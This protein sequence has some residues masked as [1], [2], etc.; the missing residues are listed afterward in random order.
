MSDPLDPRRIN[1]SPTKEFFIYM[2]TRDIPL[3]RAIL[4]LVDNSVDG[5]RA[6]RQD[7]DYS[8]LWVRIEVAR[9]SFKITDNCGGIPVD[10]A[11]NYAF[12]FGR[13]KDAPPTPHSVGQ[14]GVGM[15]RT[16]FKLGRHF[17][18]FSA[19]SHSQ[20]D[21]AIDVERWMDRPEGA[22]EES[23]ED[24]H[25]EFNN[26]EENVSN[27]APETI[28]TKIE[29]TR[30]IDTVSDSFA[31]ETFVNRLRQEMSVA[32]QVSMEKGLAVTLNSIPLQH[33]PQT[34]FVSEAIKPAFVEKLYPRQAIDGEEGPPVKVKL[35]A[36]VS[37]KS[38]HDGGW[39]IYCNGRLVVRADQT[40][41]TVWGA[42]YV[43]RNYH[44]SLANFRGYAFF[45]SDNSALLPWT[46][47]K[48]GID[49]DSAVYKHVQQE[50][51]QMSKPVITFLTQ[52]DT[53]R[54]S[55]EAGDS[56]D[57]T[58]ELAME[59]S[60][61]ERTDT[62]PA[63]TTFVAPIRPPMPPGPRMQKIQYLKLADEVKKAMDLL[64]VRTF[65]AV[66]EKTFE[67][68]MQY[69]GGE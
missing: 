9:E 23:P 12:R 14:F 10:V 5:A 37:E 61:A 8:G 4:D 27:I 16:F 36:G 60:V 55:V 31:L 7:G 39:Y 49:T 6:L 57:R 66:G 44:H 54:A 62:V 17:S 34:L 40:P 20:F 38:L 48:T 64:K 46:T 15:K 68:Y 28:G 58:L 13:P 50:M 47:T 33:S 1:A 42:A 26:V 11:R 43:G 25:F 29:V 67:Y 52:L 2:L 35:F 45:E 59:R 65:T 21:I 32:H 51:I 24:W 19:T 69:E 22:I 63:S 56:N 3:T 41:M 18:V 53:E 30:L